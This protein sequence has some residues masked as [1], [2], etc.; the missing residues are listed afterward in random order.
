M[1]CVYAKCKSNLHCIGFHLVFTTKCYIM[2]VRDVSVY[3]M[4][5]S[6]RSNLTWYSVHPKRSMALSVL[7]P[8]PFIAWLVG[9]GGLTEQNEWVS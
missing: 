1:M 6:G 9:V 3:V 8:W 2:L 4:T 5:S 7:S